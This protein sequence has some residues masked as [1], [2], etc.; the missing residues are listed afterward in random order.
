MRL[1]LARH[2]QSVWNAERRLQGA[3]TD[4][5][6]SALGRAQ[7][8][9]LGRALRGYRVAAAYVSPFRRARETAE[10]A[11]AGSGVPLLPLDELRE[12]SLGEWE[13]CTV[14]E[15]RGREG[16][17]YQQWL[18]APHDCTPP[19]GEPLEMVRDRVSAAIA[20]IAARHPNGD[21]VLVVAHGGV[22]SVYACALLGCSFNALWRLRVDN[23][24]LT[25]V[26]PPRLVSLNDTAHLPPALLTATHAR[27]SLAS[28]G[29]APAAPAPGEIAP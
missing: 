1:L 11:L 12:L 8:E 25:V 23:A 16:D 28:G 13:G 27:A 10:V 19:G 24:S 21:D 3:G 6:L 18:L 29:A 7:A 9:A 26:R 22:I 14:D 17:P 15:I 2:G 20:D 5:A 4:V